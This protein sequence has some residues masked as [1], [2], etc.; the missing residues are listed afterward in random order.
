MQGVIPLAIPIKRI[1]WYGQDWLKLD[2]DELDAFVWII[3][4]TDSFVVS[5]AQE[6]AAKKAN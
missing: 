5:K 1:H 2:E 4:R 3:R 6:K